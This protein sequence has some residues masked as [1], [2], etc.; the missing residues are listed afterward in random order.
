MVAL[1][2]EHGENIIKF[3]INNKIDINQK[4]DNGDTPLKLLLE[5]YSEQNI[6]SILS[7]FYSVNK[8]VINSIKII[9]NDENSKYFS[10]IAVFDEKDIYGWNLL[11]YRKWNNRKGNIN[12]LQIFNY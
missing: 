3:L 4:S 6:S 1:D 11:N 10:E 9:V 7:F 8:E 5:N 2:Y 12:Y